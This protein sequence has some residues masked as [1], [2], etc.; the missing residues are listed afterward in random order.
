MWVTALWEQLFPKIFITAQP[1]CRCLNS[2]AASSVGPNEVACRRP[3]GP[4][5]IRRPF[6]SGMPYR[7][8]TDTPDK[9]PA[10][11]RRLQMGNLL[12]V[13]TSGVPLVA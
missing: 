7:A 9:G 11:G 1:P 4:A 10:M 6:G 8:P 12:I 3:C 13:V 5:V 2:S